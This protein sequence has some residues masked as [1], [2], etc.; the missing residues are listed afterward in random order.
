MNTFWLWLRDMRLWLRAFGRWLV[1]DASRFWLAIVVVGGALLISLQPGTSESFIRLSGM[2]LQLL[3]LGTVA[4]G[5]AVTRALFGTDSLLTAARKWVNRVP[6]LRRGHAV[7]M[8][9]H[10]PLDFDT[11]H[12]RGYSTDNAPA[13]API[14]AR[15][16]VL[17]KNLRRVNER[18]NQTQ[19]EMDDELHKVKVS[20]TQETATRI[21]EDDSTRRTLEISETGGIYIMATGAF[22][23]LSAFFQHRLPRTFQVVTMTPAARSSA[24]RSSSRAGRQ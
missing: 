2:V 6:R 14:E 16:E 4:W 19:K 12:G 11:A 8:T 9:A 5:I 7:S 3:G 22:G 18:L 1:L 10:F 17:E 24:S 15:V 20:L 13:G 21:V 23:C